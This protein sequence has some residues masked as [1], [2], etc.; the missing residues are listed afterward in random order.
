MS[1]AVCTSKRA[2]SLLGAVGSLAAIAAFA[3]GFSTPAAAG[4]YGGVGSAM[5]SSDLDLDGIAARSG[6][7]N[8]LIQDD[9]RQAL[10]FFGG[11][12]FSDYFSVEGGYNDVDTIFA[13]VGSDTYHYD[14]TGIDI[15]V[16]G[17]LP[18]FKFLNQPI[19]LY[20][21]LG[22]INWK[23]EQT[24]NISGVIQKAED[25]GTDLVYGGGVEVILF[26]HILFRGGIDVLDIDP[27]DAGAGNI[28]LGG[29]QM[30]LNF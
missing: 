12:S 16:L 3:M 13:A 19:G 21:K 20:V 7:T 14:I 8:G 26:K 6:T 24:F 23:S 28:T 17:K 27:A 10:R 9:S 2:S 4:L 5:V 1:H 25:D 22:A 15:S 18:L 30:G 11:Y 29:V